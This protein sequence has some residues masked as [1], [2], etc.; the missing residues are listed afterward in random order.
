MKLSQPVIEALWNNGSFDGN[1]FYL[2]WQLDRKV[3][4]QVNEVLETLWGK[5]SKKD[6]A[7]IFEW[8][9]EADL[10]DALQEVVETGEVTTL[11]DI[12]KQFQFY[13]TPEELAKELVRLADI[14]PTDYVLEPSA[15][16]GAIVNQILMKQ[17]K[18]ISLIELNDENFKVLQSKYP[19]MWSITKM[20]FLW[21]TTGSYDKIIMNPP[22]AKSQDVKHILHAYSL[23]SKGWRIVAIASASVKSREWKLYDELRS[24]NPEIIDIDAWAFKASGTMVNT[25]IVILNK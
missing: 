12:I 20:D 22:F 13:E 19:N 7:H 2:G 1:K 10:E 6:K 23:L 11:K 15:W 9:E 3:Y 5:R 8:M 21:F 16:H 17:P 24:L 14:Q 18:W 25:V 4:V